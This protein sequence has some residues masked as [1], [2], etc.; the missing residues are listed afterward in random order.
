MPI[1]YVT[2]NQGE[3][4]Y[5]VAIPR[6][7]PL[8][9]A[10]IKAR[11]VEI[12]GIDR[13]LEELRKHETERRAVYDAKMTAVGEAIAGYTECRES[14]TETA[15]RSAKIADV[16]AAYDT[17]MDACFDAWRDCRDGCDLGD[18][19]CYDGCDDTRESCEAASERVRDNALAAVNRLCQDAIVAHLQS[20]QAQWAPVIAAA[21][22]AAIEALAP[23]QDTMIAIVW[24]RTKR[25][26]A[27]RRLNELEGVESSVETVTAW[28]AQYNTELPVGEV[29]EEPTGEEE[30]AVTVATV[31]GRAVITSI[32]SVNPCAHDAR[33]LPADLL[34]VDAALAPGV[35]TWR[36]TWRTGTV[37][38]IYD[39]ANPAGWPDI[40][41][42]LRVRIDPAILPGTLGTPVSRRNIECTP[43][44]A[45]FDANGTLDARLGIARQEYADA[46]E[47]R[48]EIL[49]EIA[50]CQATYTVESCTATRNETCANNRDASL[51]IC[52]DARDECLALASDDNGVQY[53]LDQ[54]AL[55][56]EQVDAI[57]SACVDAATADCVEAKRQHDSRCKR[58]RLN[59]LTQA[60]TAI[61]TA[62]RNLRNATA[63]TQ[64]PPSELE[65]DAEVGHCVAKSYSVGD[66]VLIDFP[67]RATSTG[68]D[69]ATATSEQIKAAAMAV[70]QSARVVG[71]ASN[72]KECNTMLC[73]AY[74]SLGDGRY[75]SID[76]DRVVRVLEEKRFGQRYTEA[77]INGQYYCLSW[78]TE[79]VGDYYRR[80]FYVGGRRLNTY[81]S[82]TRWELLAAYFEFKNSTLYLVQ[83]GSD[84]VWKNS[85]S[86]YSEPSIVV[87]ASP[88]SF[89]IGDPVVFAVGGLAMP[90]G[91]VDHVTVSASGASA[92]CQAR[93]RIIDGK[94]SCY[95]FE[96]ALPEIPAVVDPTEPI[97]LDVTSV[98]EAIDNPVSVT[99]LV[100]TVFYYQLNSV[101]RSTLTRIARTTITEN[102]EVGYLRETITDYT[103]DDLEAQYFNRLQVKDGR[104][105]LTSGGTLIDLFYASTLNIP[106]VY[107]SA[108]FQYSPDGAGV[109][110]S[111]RLFL[112]DVQASEIPADEILS[113][114]EIRRAR[115]WWSAQTGKH[116]VYC[117]RGAW[118]SQTE[119][120]L[121][122]NGEKMDDL[123]EI[124]YMIPA[125]GSPSFLES[126]Y[127]DPEPYF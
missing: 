95:A 48:D 69:W 74:D 12:D 52:Q 23:L 99:D 101:R 31:S 32:S 93:T 54:Y 4:R 80:S 55:C 25:T 103:Y 41:K 118:S 30:H 44:G 11:R 116:A 34:F 114:N 98:G 1:G 8:L 62:L 79:I 9:A 58:E 38:A 75:L 78:S 22:A 72:T 46:I 45:F 115:G 10:L 82:L 108:D 121:F 123:G 124:Y 33:A 68:L 67:V 56:T 40:E 51:L 18:G 70:W 88:V 126:I 35:E 117:D 29:P 76:S 84:E 106:V 83:I 6:R 60:E 109:T 42:P 17:A 127:I 96:F 81:T 86:G 57:F 15:C 27:V 120:H 5:T 19:D 64:G 43:P 107:A 63:D 104:S 125:S 85:G 47:A 39:P 110:G 113:I 112:G 7:T 94:E 111:D 71:W 66:D 53:C 50:A 24:E 36:P 122:L 37:T 119:R 65:I 87:A 26:A 100:T 2:A 73:H 14:Y 20:C 49:A 91:F 3:S 92:L 102:S 61:S 16:E 105:V 28:S 90:A 77:R 21:Q 13:V 97:V 89:L 59:D